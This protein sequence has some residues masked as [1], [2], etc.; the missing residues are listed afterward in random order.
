MDLIPGCGRARIAG[1]LNR[2][3]LALPE[4]FSNFSD[5][6]KREWLG[7]AFQKIFS[8][9]RRLPNVPMLAR[10]KSNA[11]LVFRSYRGQVET[12]VFDG[13]AAASAVVTDLHK[14]VQQRVR[15]N[16]VADSG[17]KLNPFRTRSAIADDSAN[18]VRWRLDD[19]IALQ[20]K[21]GDSEEEL[22]VGLH[23][24]KRADGGD[25]S[26]VAGHIR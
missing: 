1:Q 5:R 25:L 14:L 7:A 9:R 22:A 19:G 16:V 11:E 23:L 17:R 4:K 3:K 13:Q 10:I 8:C 2:R 20:A 6:R 26:S 12:P 24:Q 21:V 15:Q 18:L